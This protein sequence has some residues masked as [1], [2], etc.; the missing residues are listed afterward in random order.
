VEQ[1][2]PAAVRCV[3]DD[4]ASLTVHPRFPAEHWH[5]IRHSNFIERTF[6]ETRRCQRSSVSGLTR[7]HDHDQRARGR[8]RLTATSSARSANS[9]LGRGTWRRVQELA[10]QDEDLQ[11]LGGVAVG[12]QHEQLDGTA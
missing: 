11:V 5:R 8:T 3:T 6:G 1:P 7:K 10:A 12:E 9:S 2:L 4:L